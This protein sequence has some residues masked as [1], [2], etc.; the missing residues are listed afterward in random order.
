MCVCGYVCM[1]VCVYVRT[2]VCVSVEAVSGPDIQPSMWSISTTAMRVAEAAFGFRKAV[3]VNTCFPPIR[4][5]FCP[6]ARHHFS[7]CPKRILVSE[8]STVFGGGV[9]RFLDG[10]PRRFFL[11]LKNRSGIRYQASEA[12]FGFRPHPGEEHFCEFRTRTLTKSATSRGEAFRPRLD[13]ILQP[14]TA[15]GTGF[16]T[17]VFPVILNPIFR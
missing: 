12:D 8:F 17:P 9:Q 6:W 4:A 3:L 7:R 10:A 14:K 16:C 15:S 1:N 13:R 5:H 11:F 2:C